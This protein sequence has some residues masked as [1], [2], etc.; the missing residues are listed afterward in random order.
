M[1]ALFSQRGL[2][3]ESIL[4]VRSHIGT[5]GLILNLLKLAAW[6]VLTGISP[7]SAQSVP[8]YG[9]TQVRFASAA[10]SRQLLAT[11][12]AFVAAMSIYDRSARTGRRDAV[13]ETDFVQFAADQALEWQPAEVA[14]L[15]LSIAGI[16]ELLRTLKLPLPREVLLV[17]TTGREEADTPYTRGNAIVMPQPYLTVAAAEIDRVIIHEIFHVISRH[18][19]ERR[20]A[21]YAI[22]GFRDCGPLAWP[23]ELEPRRITNPD[24]PD[25]RYCIT[26][27]RD[28]DAETFYPVLFAKEESFDPTLPGTFLERMVFRLLAVMGSGANW[29]V[30][31]AGVAL[32]LLDPG[33]VPEYFSAIGRNTRYIIHPEEILA[34]NFILLVRGERKVRTPRILDEL[35]RV[36]A[37][38]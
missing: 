35:E 9:A 2:P 26:L 8:L 38:K 13:T 14:K 4:S 19:P 30:S 1:D 20:N 18:V 37:G 21:L 5:N 29:S 12:D 17:K 7:A 36:L 33:S 34:D 16:S 6:L 23:P 28:S 11:R 24:A 15:S 22:V 31:R 10:E 27:E 3:P 32:V 25:S